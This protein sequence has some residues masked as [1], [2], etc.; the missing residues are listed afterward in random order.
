[1]IPKG[2]EINCEQCQ[3][4]LAITQRDLRGGE[5][6][7]ESDFFFFTYEDPIYEESYRNYRCPQCYTVF[8]VRGCLHTREG[9]MNADGIVSGFQKK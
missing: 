1:M 5:K 9:W 8:F 3:M 4:L 7:L 6:P 2:T